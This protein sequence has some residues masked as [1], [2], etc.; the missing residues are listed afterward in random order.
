MIRIAA[1]IAMTTP[2][3]AENF[4]WSDYDGSFEDAAFSVEQA[5][6]GAASRDQARRT[7][8]EDS[9]EFHGRE[10]S[11]GQNWKTDFRF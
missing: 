10:V 1:L 3:A 7:G 4:V 6:P 8:D 5:D 11:G 9:D 2:L